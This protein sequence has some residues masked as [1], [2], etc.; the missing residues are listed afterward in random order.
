[1]AAAAT[2]GATLSA[3]GAAIVADSTAAD[4]AELPAGP[5]P[6]PTV[7][8]LPPTNTPHPTSPPAATNTAEA[9]PRI[10]YFRSAVTEADPGDTI[11]LEWETDGATYVAL[12]HLLPTGQYGGGDWVVELDGSFQYE[13]GDRERNLTRFVLIAVD[14]ESHF[15]YGYVS[16]S[17]R[18]LATW[19]FS[20]APDS[21]PFDPPAVSAGAEQ[22]FEQGAM[23]WLATQ[24]VVYVLYDDGQFP[25]WSVHPDEW[26]PGDPETDP[27]L[28]PPPGFYQPVRGF[29][30]V[31]REQLGV[32]GRLG[33]ALEPE[34]AYQ[35]AFQTT[36]YPR[37]N[38]V[39]V[40]ALD[41]NVWRIMPNG[42]DWQKIFTNE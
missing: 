24:D 5:S 30:L 10:V 7:T 38:D 14:E 9:G 15:S 12:H 11:T 27:S 42:S 16:V 19:F 2:S 34:A 18:C 33:W 8:P 25:R 36:S 32:R 3:S 28:M 22:P 40:R 41:G 17:L 39:Y 13:I 21:C 4:N 31:W 37:Y 29:G 6:G 20:P 35:T 1:L 26:D 23:I